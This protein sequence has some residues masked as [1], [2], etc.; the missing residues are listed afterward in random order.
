M[1]SVAEWGDNIMLSVSQNYM[2]FKTFRKPLVN[3]HYCEQDSIGRSY[4][5]KP[6]G[7]IWEGILSL[8]YISTGKL[9]AK[10]NELFF[11]KIDCQ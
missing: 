5:Y 6:T 1:V 2:N 4:F 11:Q 8:Y 3:A 7:Y 10:M 9:N